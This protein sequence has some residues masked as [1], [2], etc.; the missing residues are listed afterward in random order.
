MLAADALGDRE[1]PPARA[2]W[3]TTKPAAAVI[4][5]MAMRPSGARKFSG[6]TVPASSTARIRAGFTN[7]VANL[8]AEAVNNVAVSPN[9]GVDHPCS[10]PLR[11]SV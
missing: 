4:Y 7:M 11:H 3:V 10:A 1:Y 6:P 5:E 8:P 9:Y 2:S